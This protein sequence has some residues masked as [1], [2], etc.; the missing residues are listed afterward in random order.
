[1]ATAI[2]PQRPLTRGELATLIYQGWVHQ[3]QREAI[4]SP[5]IIQ[6]QEPLALFTDVLNPAQPRHW[7]EAF[8]RGL[9]DLGLL[10]GFDDGTFRPEAP[11]ARVD[12]AGML[13]A[14]FDPPP[15]S[16][17]EQVDV[18]RLFRDVAAPPAAQFKVV[19]RIYRSGAMS[20]F[21]DGTFGVTRPISREQAIS[22]LVNILNLE[23]GNPSSLNRY[24]D[25]ATLSPWATGAIAAATEAGL[26]V[27]AASP[28]PDPIRAK[29][30]AT[31]ADVAAL[32]Y[33]GLR[34]LPAA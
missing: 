16:D 19:D 13:V 34:L 5:H 32:V 12:Y 28:A 3:G 8:I 24:P 22:A 6:L 1:M 30:P 10:N 21:D 15:R 23:A 14:A 29:E 26:I 25:R 9:V 18:S 33:Q 31:R 2:E 27:S 11:V 17:R 4:A 7:A 20:G